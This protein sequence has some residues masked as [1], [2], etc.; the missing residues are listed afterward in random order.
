MNQ[1]YQFLKGHGVPISAVWMQDWVGTNQF[2]EGERLLWN[3]QLNQEKYPDWH[4][5]TAQWAK[6][7]VK[8]FIYINPYFA[9]L[10][11]FYSP[12]EDQFEI[13]VEKGYFLKK[14]DGSVYMMKS[15]SIEFA[16]VDLANPEARTWIKEIIKRNLIEE[17]GAGGWMHD[18]G[19]YTPFDAVPHET[20]S[21]DYHNDYPTLW[22]AVC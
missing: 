16:M 7:G 10:T 14:A 11:G 20:N 13:G 9:N 3:W 4:N 6:E 18:F 1:Q 22:A 15:I 17:A 2:F 5:M 8:P 12:R 21:F 19:E